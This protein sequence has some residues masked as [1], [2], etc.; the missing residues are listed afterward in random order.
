MAAASPMLA[1]AGAGRPAGPD[2]RRLTFIIGGP[3]SG[4][5]WLAKM[6]DSNPDVLY[7]H[8]PDTILR[9]P[10][11]P[12]YADARD[13]ARFGDATRR[14]TEALLDL[15]LLKTAGSLPSFPK[16]YQSASARLLR[17]GIALGLRFGERLPGVGRSLARR[18]AIPDGVDWR[19]SPALRLVIKSVSARGRAALLARA[20]PGSAVVV[21]LR[22]PC[23]NVA[24]ELKG[25]AG[26]LFETPWN[27]ED[28]LKNPLAAAYGLTAARFGV[29][30]SLEQH[31]WH[32]MLANEFALR[33]LAAAPRVRVIR[34]E[35]LC[36]RPLELARALLEFADL[37]WHP[38]TEDFIGRSI[39]YTGATRYYGV[40]RN[41]PLAAER[42]REEM[43]REDQRRIMA[44]IRQSPLAAFYP[45]P[46]ILP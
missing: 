46:D 34:Y 10:D 6:F 38:Q 28:V 42:W 25:E 21:I 14:W 1:P 13:T 18:L 16:S 30:S 32:W 7:R 37:G 3:R 2:W 8:E 41:T 17:L 36:A 27:P 44:I 39:S 11:L 40:F 26:G 4:T 35:D 5:T 43:P 23:G 20:L 29:L 31:A 22:H 9:N 19:S 12:L 15:R 33:A 45:E 24:S